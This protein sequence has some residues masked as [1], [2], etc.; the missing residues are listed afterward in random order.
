MYAQAIPLMR[1]N[2][3][4]FKAVSDPAEFA[5]ELWGSYA[6]TMLHIHAQHKAGVHNMHT[7]LVLAH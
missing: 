1:K 7:E 2:K 4:Q 5:P 6:K 3:N